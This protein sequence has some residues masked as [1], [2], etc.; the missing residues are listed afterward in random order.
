MKEY[1]VVVNVNIT[2]FYNKKAKSHNSINPSPIFMRKETIFCKLL[3]DIRQD[4]GRF[5]TLCYQHDL[6][7][8]PLIQFSWSVTRA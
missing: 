6:D 2:I 8:W 4:E 5:G 3:I 7:N 1:N